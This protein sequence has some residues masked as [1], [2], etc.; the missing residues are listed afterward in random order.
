MT[1]SE[2][3]SQITHAIIGAAIE[4]HKGRTRII[5]IIIMKRVW[6]MNWVFYG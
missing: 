1:D 3:Y 4:L 6:F 2:I 5:R